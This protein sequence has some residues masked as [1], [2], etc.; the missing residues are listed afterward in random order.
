MQLYLGEV[1]EELTKGKRHHTV[2]KFVS[3]EVRMRLSFGEV[4][5]RSDGRSLQLQFQPCLSTIA[6]CSV[7]TSTSK[8]LTLVMA[9]PFGGSWLARW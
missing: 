8:S 6:R 4:C 7:F 5:V 9:F 1:Y 2:D 3:S